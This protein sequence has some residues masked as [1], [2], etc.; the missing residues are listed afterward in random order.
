LQRY[1]GL[2]VRFLIIGVVVLTFVGF[3]VS[4]TVGFNEKAVVATFGR[5]DATSVIDA[6]GLRFRVPYVH[7]VT[8]YDTRLRLVESTPETQS[9]ADQRQLVFTAYMT[10]RVADPLKFYQRFSGSGDGAG[11][12]YAEAERI[13]VTK[14]RSA[15]TEVGQYRLDQLLAADGAASQLPELE[16]RILEMLSRSSGGPAAGAALADSGIVP[17]AVGISTISLPQEVTKSVIDR[18]NG[19]RDK[20]INE[21]ISQG[22]SQ[23]AAIRSS[24]DNDAKRILA[25]AQRLAGEL[26]AKGDAEVA[27]FTKRMNEKP[28]LAVFLKNMELMRVAH[29][30]S[31]TLVLPT[32]I[33]G[34]EFF[35]PGASGM[36][37]SGEI[38][39]PGLDRLTAPPAPNVRP[40]A[41]AG[42]D[43]AV[44]GGGR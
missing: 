19:N 32:S 6:P 5:A 42:S 20:I 14:L 2:F 17:V 10:W 43:A 8:K 39:V 34:L 44:P 4:Y 33:P 9:T 22:A 23:A 1:T 18:M 3:M 36:F 16:T 15:M 7:S 13:L 35:S 40:A 25:F 38:P 27:E 11:D 29:G 31:T 12:H 28:E 37:N 21:T 41:D 26:R 24:A 30:R